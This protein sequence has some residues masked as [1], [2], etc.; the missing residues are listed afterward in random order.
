MLPVPKLLSSQTRRITYLQQSALFSKPN[1]E[2]LLQL[3][4][5]HLTALFTHFRLDVPFG[6]QFL[7]KI[8]QLSSSTLENGSTQET[9]E[10]GCDRSQGCCGHIQGVLRKCCV[11][12]CNGLDQ[13]DNLPDSFFVGCYLAIII[14]CSFVFFVF[15]LFTPSI[16]LIAL[17]IRLCKDRKSRSYRA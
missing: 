9:Y 6:N 11:D 4:C 2:R 7:L 10:L 12:H 1:Y 13:Y 14:V 15:F 16:F 3:L 17:I 5:K 8:K